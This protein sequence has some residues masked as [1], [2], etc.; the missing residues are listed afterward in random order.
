VTLKIDN[1]KQQQQQPEPKYM[2]SLLRG[3]PPSNTINKQKET[4]RNKNVNK[5]KPAQNF[6]LKNALLNLKKTS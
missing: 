2:N 3:P 6:F 5:E 1:A 4:K